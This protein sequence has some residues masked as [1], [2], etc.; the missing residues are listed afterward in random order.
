MMAFKRL[1]QGMRMAKCR[2]DGEWEFSA[3]R[4]RYAAKEVRGQK[5]IPRHRTRLVQDRTK[6]TNRLYS[7]T[8]MT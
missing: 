4:V 6:A 7:L 8:S 5:E 1:T 2:F 3:G